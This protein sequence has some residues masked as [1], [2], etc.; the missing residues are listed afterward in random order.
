VRRFLL[1]AVT[2]VVAGCSAPSSAGP[3]G[4]ASVAHVVDGDTIDVA[5]G[6]RRERVRLTGITTPETVDRRRPVEC[7]GHEA[8]EHPKSLLP[9][10]TEVDLVRDVEPRDACGRLLA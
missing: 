6:G 7:F 5:I 9:A 4:R 3:P 2:F 10:G 1:V 8:S